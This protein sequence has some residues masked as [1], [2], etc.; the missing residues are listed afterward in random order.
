M[1]M[2]A[3]FSALKALFSLTFTD[4]FIMHKSGCMKTFTDDFIKQKSGCMKTISTISKRQIMRIKD[5]LLNS[6]TS[7]K[8]K[9]SRVTLAQYEVLKP[10]CFLN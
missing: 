5:T 9:C 1:S 4:D 3:V 8:N 2:M 6:I 7:V 10:N